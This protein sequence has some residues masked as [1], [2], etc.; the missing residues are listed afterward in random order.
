MR[1]FDNFLN[2]L[3][4]IVTVDDFTNN[5]KDAL[6]GKDTTPEEISIILE[7]FEVRD[8]FDD[9][10]LKELINNLSKQQKLIASIEAINS[11]VS[12]IS[13]HISSS[14]N[15][16]IIELIISDHGDIR[17]LG[18]KIFD[19]VKPTIED[20]GILN[21]DEE[22]QLRFAFSL[23]QDYGDAEN[24]AKNICCFFNSDS[25]VV[26]SNL[27]KIIIDY[28]LNYFGLF[29]KI[30]EDGNFKESEELI[31]Y[32]DL[33]T[34]LNERFELA[35]KCVELHSDNFFPHIFEIARQSEQENMRDNLRKYDPKH[36]SYV[37]EF[38]HTITLGR[39]GG[40]RR[41]GQ[42][43]P[44]ASI[45]SKMSFPMML[46]SQTPLENREFLHNIQRNWGVNNKDNE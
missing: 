18:R 5:V 26:R 27:V 12:S 2:I 44:L 6:F 17:L 42:I 40:V 14:I 11:L 31:Y 33:L 15:S 23:I 24:R 36:K 13:E 4:K 38:F 25:E 30:I 21:L 43:I 37:S 1:A 19:T 32:K 7:R 28:T 8:L 45:T 34:T 3:D 10:L 16:L 39:G 46:A 22:S 35:S 20:M 9:R 29:K 41:D